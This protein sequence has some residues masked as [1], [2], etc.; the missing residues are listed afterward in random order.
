MVWGILERNSRPLFQL[1]D[2][3]IAAGFAAFE[4]IDLSGLPL[5]IGIQRR[6]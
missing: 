2:A 3:P 5:S 1:W 4:R 6:W